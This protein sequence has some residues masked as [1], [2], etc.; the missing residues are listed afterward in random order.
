MG[1]RVTMAEK[2]AYCNQ[3]YGEGN[4]KF[5]TRDEFVALMMQA[6]C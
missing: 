1:H 2:V 4:W 6:R 3:V 5:L